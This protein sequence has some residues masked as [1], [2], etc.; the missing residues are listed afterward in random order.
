MRS[1]GWSSDVCSSDLHHP[2]GR[3]AVVR[4]HARV[5]PHHP[6]VLLV[7]LAVELVVDVLS[8]L[9]RA[10]PSLRRP[11][12]QVRDVPGLALGYRKSA[13]QGT[14]VSV[15]LDLGVRSNITIQSLIQSLIYLI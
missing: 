3:V 10:H 9:Q 7:D 1:S 15:R 4:L 13:G 2:P 6:A 12:E 8:A 5:A 14:R 11:H